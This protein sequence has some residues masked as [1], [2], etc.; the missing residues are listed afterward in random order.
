[1]YGIL[2]A[3]TR[4]RFSD[5]PP[6]LAYRI[7]EF[8]FQT[9]H[10]LLGFRVGL[11][12]VC[13]NEYPYSSWENQCSEALRTPVSGDGR[14]VLYGATCNESRAPPSSFW[15]SCE[16]RACQRGLGMWS[17]SN[18]SSPAGEEAQVAERGARRGRRAER[19]LDAPGVKHGPQCRGF[20]SIAKASE[21]NCI[22]RLLG[23]KCFSVNWG[24]R[25]GVLHSIRRPIPCIFSWA[26]CNRVAVPLL[27]ITHDIRSRPSP[28]VS[29]RA[30][31]NAVPHLCFGVHL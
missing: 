22:S 14:T 30:F 2:S 26:H 6:D 15:E 8:C 17:I 28:L 10:S 13:R 18:M 16:D 20:P 19:L 3:L 31:A 4:K 21:S 11:C 24:L 29:G 9:M 7:A 5:G 27:D 1:M 25:N 12:R 23:Q